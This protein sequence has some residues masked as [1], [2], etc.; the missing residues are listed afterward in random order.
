MSATSTSAM[1]LVQRAISFAAGNQLLLVR[2]DFRETFGAIVIRNSCG[3]QL[4]L[5]P[6]PQPLPYQ[7]W[8]AR[9]KAS[10]RFG[11]RNGSGVPR[12]SCT[13]R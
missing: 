8:G 12:I 13:S 7:G 5:K 6:N 1:A 2:S 3:V 11:E 9:L 4:S 10:L